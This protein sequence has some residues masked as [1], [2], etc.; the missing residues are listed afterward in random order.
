[1][2]SA[3]FALVG[4]FAAML[5]N[6]AADCWLA[7]TPLACGLTRHPRRAA[8]VTVALP[9]V[10]V[11]AGQR[12]GSAG[13]ALAITLFAAVLLLLAV[14]DWEQRRL[15]NVVVL[16]ALAA[17]VA[18]SADP[19]AAGLA[20]AAAF[21]VFLAL[22]GLGRRFYGPGALGMGDVK[23]AALVAAVVGPAAA[24]ALLGGMLLAGGAAAVGLLSGRVGRGAALPYGSFLAV[25]GVVVLL[26]GL[27]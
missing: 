17:A 24:A 12:A 18:L 11:L 16:P 4:L 20:A 26:W 25:A 7:P 23:L 15:P 3:L 8:A 5:L 13:V 19:L 9:L 2:P 1:M 14:V 6:R 27:R 22:Y 10:A 21:V